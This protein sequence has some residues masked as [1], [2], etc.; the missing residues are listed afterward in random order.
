MDNIFS[1]K[2]VT[3]V[4]ICDS[5]CWSVFHNSKL[6][7]HDSMLQRCHSWWRFTRF[8]KSKHFSSIWQKIKKSNQQLSKRF[9]TVNSWGNLSGMYI[10][11]E[12]KVLLL[13]KLP[14]NDQMQ[15]WPILTIKC[16]ICEK[17]SLHLF[18]QIEK[19]SFILAMIRYCKGVWFH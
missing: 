9:I 19:I 7:C 16:W 8:L 6:W 3:A 10:N 12:Y 1:L 4:K 15:K 5:F 13:E 18:L 11:V 14:S 2:H 17:S